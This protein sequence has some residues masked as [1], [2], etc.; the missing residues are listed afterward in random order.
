MNTQLPKQLL[1]KFLIILQ[2]RQA[3]VKEILSKEKLFMINNE[4][5]SNIFKRKMKNLICQKNIYL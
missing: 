1:N 5:S 2:F 4:L 3:I